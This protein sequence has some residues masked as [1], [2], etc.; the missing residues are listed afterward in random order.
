[1]ARKET[2]REFQE[3]LQAKMDAARSGE[4]SETAMYFGVAAGGVNFLLHGADIQGVY[5]SSHLDPI[6]A[7]K[8]WVAGAANI[9]GTVHAVTDLAVL[10]GRPR[11][12]RGMFLVVNS[13]T[14]SGAALMIDSLTGLHAEERAGEE[15]NERLDGAH[16]EWVGACYL[17]DGRKFFMLD[18]AKLA[19]DDR[20]AKLQ[21][22]AEI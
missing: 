21:V 17:I 4:Y 9:K 11:T 7:S 10:L 3:A 8:P 12:Q 5:S 19:A 16:P 6:P 18:V 1:M 13:Q 22:Q 14:L 15:I 2:L 20:F